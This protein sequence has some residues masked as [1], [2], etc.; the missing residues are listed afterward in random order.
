MTTNGKEKRTREVS[1]HQH[2]DMCDWPV[3]IIQQYG[4]N[5]EGEAFVCLLNHPHQST[6]WL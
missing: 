1:G 5:L 4:V 3:G 2:T 6:I